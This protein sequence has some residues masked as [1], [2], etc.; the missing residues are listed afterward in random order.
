MRRK[1]IAA[2][3]VLGIAMVCTSVAALGAGAFAETAP[4]APTAP[5]ASASDGPTADGPTTSVPATDVPAGSASTT[6]PADVADSAAS[7]ST[8]SDSAASGSTASNSGGAALPASDPMSA[9]YNPYTTPGDPQYVTDADK[10]TW[11]ALQDVIRSCMADAGLVYLDFEWWE[12]GDPQ[13]SRQSQD[14]KITWSTA[15]YGSYAPPSADRIAS[16]CSG[17]ALYITGD[18]V[19]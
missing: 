5:T 15:M 18:T 4:T 8:T 13:P 12:G 1:L 19:H 14:E 6:E 16:G 11:F 17:Y 9:A 2:A 7:G 3:A 10:V